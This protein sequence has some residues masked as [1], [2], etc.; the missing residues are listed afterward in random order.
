MHTTEPCT[1]DLGHIHDASRIRI[2]PADHVRCMRCD[3]R[4]LYVLCVALAWKFLLQSIGPAEV[5]DSSIPA[6]KRYDCLQGD[7]RASTTTPHETLGA[8]RKEGS[9]RLWPHGQGVFTT[10]SLWALQRYKVR[11]HE[12]HGKSSAWR[13]RPCVG[14]SNAPAGRDTPTMPQESQEAAPGRP[15]PSDRCP[16]SFA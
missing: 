1:T 12:A 14:P 9:R 10:S 5:R 2:R 8:T 15:T 13:K 3:P 4:R 6:S 16:S 11:E 7:P